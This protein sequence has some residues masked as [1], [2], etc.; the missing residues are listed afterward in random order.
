MV[1][2]G[3]SDDIPTAWQAVGGYLAAD[4]VDHNR[5]LT[6]FDAVLDDPHGAAAQG[7]RC[8]WAIETGT[9]QTLG[10]CLRTDAAGP[11]LLAAV[12]RATAIV[13]ANAVAA[14]VAQIPGVVGPPDLATAFAGV[15]ASARQV[16]VAVALA[17]RFYRLDH[18]APDTNH[19]AGVARPGRPDDLDLLTTWAEGFQGDAFGPGVV[20]TPSLHPMMAAK[21]DCG[22]VWLFCPGRSDHLGAA[23]SGPTSMAA[24]TPIVAGVSRIQHVYTPPEH[25]RRGY[26]AACV[27]QVV[28]RRQA[29][30]AKHCVLYADFANPSSNAIYQRLGFQPHREEIELDF[31]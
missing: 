7:A 13:L 1:E 11:C 19:P 14:A 25:R 3:S 27:A 12:N 9:T 22:L 29:A 17:Q 16:G 18:L 20:D 30:G 28:A 26:A 2:I 15:W 8:W 5:L 6:H 21:V 24:A 4:P 23:L 10:V 31:G